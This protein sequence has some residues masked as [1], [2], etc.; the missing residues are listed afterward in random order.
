[1]A[2]LLKLLILSRL[3]KSTD[4]F[5]RPEQF[6]YTVEHSTTNQL[7]KLIEELAITFSRKESTVAIFLDF[8]KAFDKV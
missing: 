5:I 3:K 6:V 4:Q 7:T 2:K 8:E 1:M